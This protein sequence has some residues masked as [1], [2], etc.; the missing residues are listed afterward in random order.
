M[1]FKRL[2]LLAL[3]TGYAAF[4][5][6]SGGRELEE[7]LLSALRLKPGTTERAGDSGKAIQAYMREGVVNKR[8][9]Q[10]ADYTDYYVLKKPA[11]FMGHELVVIEE[12][13]MSKYIGC[14]VNPGAGVT[15]KLNGSLKNLERFAEA[16]MCSFD[17][18][19]DAQ[20]ELNRVSIRTPLSKGRY[21]RLSC[22]ENDTRR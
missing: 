2:F 9:D 10:R 20:G 3:L 4:A 13:Y 15:V 19:V 11:S 5:A 1:M 8:P 17:D 14:C 18:N 21:A 12:E 16:N 6:A 7:G 22:R